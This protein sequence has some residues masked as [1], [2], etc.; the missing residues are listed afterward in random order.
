MESKSVVGSDVME[1]RKFVRVPIRLEAFVTCASHTFRAEIKNLSLNGMLLGTS[2][3]VAEGETVS[4]ILYLIGAEQRLDLSICLAG[5]V[6]RCGNGHVALKFQE[7][8]IDS[9][10][11]LRNIIAYNLGDADLVMKEF[12][13]SLLS[14]EREVKEAV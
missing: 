14:G 10:T 11:Q 4:V 1:K 3:A 2:E 7:M 13:E 8:D 6:L 12:F 9:F 5:K